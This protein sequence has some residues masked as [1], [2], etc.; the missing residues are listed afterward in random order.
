MLGKRRFL[1]TWLF[2]RDCLCQ[3]T[4]K[5]V[6]REGHGVMAPRMFSITLA[7]KDKNGKSLWNPVIF[8]VCWLFPKSPRKCNIGISELLN[9]KFSRGACPHTSLE[10]CP[11]S[12]Q[13]SVSY[14]LHETTLYSLNYWEPYIK[15]DAHV[16]CT[17]YSPITL[18]LVQFHSYKV[19]L[20]TWHWHSHILSQCYFWL[21]IRCQNCVIVL[22]VNGNEVDL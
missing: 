21:P 5:A 20:Y 9:I 4:V 12:T 15:N 13:I 19:E 14:L 17:V 22:I 8:L 18:H 2:N 3:R 11:F 1:G 6:A 7:L 16:H 10:A